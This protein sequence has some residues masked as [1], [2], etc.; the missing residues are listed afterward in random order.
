MCDL[1]F[2]AAVNQSSA[3]ATGFNSNIFYEFRLILLSLQTGKHFLGQT[4][5]NTFSRM[6]EVASKI[7][8]TLLVLV[9]SVFRIDIG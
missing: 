5:Y 6:D 7:F 2:R 3:H 1:R 4:L 9:D 8:L